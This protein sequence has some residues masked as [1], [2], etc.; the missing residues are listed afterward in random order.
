MKPL[1]KNSDKCEIKNNPLITLLPVIST[2][3]DLE[4]NNLLDNSQHGFQSGRSVLIAA[5]EFIESVIDSLD[6]KQKIEEL[7]HQ[8]SFKLLGGI[9][10]KC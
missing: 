2:V 7:C 9:L 3:F 8:Q 10:I 1:F 5:T 4:N 6:N